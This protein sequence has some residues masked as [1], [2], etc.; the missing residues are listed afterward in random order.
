MARLP[1]RSL[2]NSRRRDVSATID[3][4]TNARQMP[5]N[6]SGAVGSV[7]DNLNGQP[8]WKHFTAD[9]RWVCPFCM[10]A[11]RNTQETRASLIRQVESHIHNRCKKYH[12]GAGVV[13]AQ[14]ALEQRVRVFEIEQRA[15]NDKAWQV[16]DHEGYWYSPSSLERVTSVQIQNRRFDA[17]TIE[18][19]TK[20]LLTCQRFH[21]GEI[22]EL[23]EVQ[24]VREQFMRTQQLA[25]NLLKV[26]GQRVWQYRTN[27]GAWVCPYCTKATSTVPFGQP[28]DWDQTATGMAQHLLTD[29]AVYPRNPQNIQTETD[30]HAA[31]QRHNA[32]AQIQTQQQGQTPVIPIAGHAQ[33][34]VDA[35]AL[36]PPQEEPSQTMSLIHSGDHQTIPG[37]TPVTSP[38]PDPRIAQAVQQ[39]TPE[40]RVARAVQQEPQIIAPAI[41]EPPPIAQ[42]T[43]SQPL[44]APPAASMQPPPPIAQSI[45][46]TGVPTVGQTASH[47]PPIATPVTKAKE[48]TPPVAMPNN[49]RIA[50]P[51]P[52][53]RS[54]RSPLP[55]AAP[56]LDDDEA[57]PLTAD[58]LLHP[59][60]A[61]VAETAPRIARAVSDPALEP[62]DA[63][64]IEANN[65]NDALDT[66]FGQ[67]DEPPPPENE[68]AA[69]KTSSAVL[70]AI[71]IGEPQVV[72]KFSPEA[73]ESDNDASGEEQALSWMDDISASYGT[74]SSN[75]TD[76]P[77]KEPSEA[78]PHTGLIR[79]RH[80]QQGMLNDCPR[81]PG[82]T[83]ATRFEPAGELSGD[84][85]EFITLSDGRIGFAQGDVSGHG[86]DAALIM[87]M[88]K[89]VFSIYAHQ[90]Q[91]SP[92]KVLSAVNDALVD[93]LGGRK[94][95]SM[96]YAILD[97]QNRTLRWARAGHNP[98]ICYNIHTKE[99][100]EIQPPGM[101][102]GMKGGSLFANLIKEEET[103][104][105]SG[106]VFVVYTDGITETMNRQK[107]E[108]DIERLNILITDHAD[109]GL[110][111][112]FDRILDSVRQFR[113]GSPTEDDM[114]LLGLS[115]E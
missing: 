66:F 90:E 27:H 7:R 62:T 106:D 85:Y 70:P 45:S 21:A 26:I 40:P 82:Y 104:I 22:H 96:T 52:D 103:Q 86:M 78:A 56:V 1:R 19:M 24:H 43:T 105:R 87:S 109:K 72:E 71:T 9:G 95:I 111:Q 58:R 55:Q 2:N 97:P 33:K 3:G 49:I 67:M 44:V 61:T 84:F 42:P 41:E 50:T 102:V 83:F 35:F 68:Q 64:S 81:I 110:D 25:I 60:S 17:F 31:T 98:T 34:P 10:S 77:V 13:Q 39:Q 89:K 73:A 18:R 100:T 15:R 69:R 11:I 30:V 54:F 108:Y 114:T 80:V 76:E 115:V 29:C 5:D 74:V 47:T 8:A 59:P 65:A 99:L 6:A 12:N 51:L 91:E 32:L 38:A 23:A 94:F 75:T 14:A 20:H 37:A 113:G 46:Q 79:A 36:Q 88:A 57:S 28:I 63:L 4:S 92:A 107:E 112:L 93:D 16:F 48:P 53:R 101:V